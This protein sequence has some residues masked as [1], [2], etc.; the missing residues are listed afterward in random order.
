MLSS[1]H[2]SIKR[3]IQLKIG[4][5][6]LP[7]ERLIMINR[8]KVMSFIAAKQ[9]GKA[10]DFYENKLGLKLISEDQ[11]ALVFDANGTM[12]RVQKVPDFTPHPF[13]A[14]GWEVD[15][16]AKS[17]D[18]LSEKG[19]VFARYEWMDQ[20]ERCIWTTPDGT[21]VAWFN[22]QD[23]NVLSLTQFLTAG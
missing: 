11:Y 10:K 21:K 18:Q 7:R 8:S 1:F 23:G 14:L 16:I 9:P 12:L 15:D 22:D 6:E 20:D 19:V 17:I 2:S 3:H 4:K 5:S 13:T